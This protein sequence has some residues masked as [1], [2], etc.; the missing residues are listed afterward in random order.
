MYVSEIKEQAEQIEHCFDAGGRDLL[1]EYLKKL[2]KCDCE[3]L[4][5]VEFLI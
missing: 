1:E 4:E 5:D 3:I 2:E